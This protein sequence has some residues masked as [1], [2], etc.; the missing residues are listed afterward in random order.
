MLLL[1]GRR[2]IGGLTAGCGGA[3][4]E[5]V[6]VDDHADE[7][8]PAEAHHQPDHQAHVDF[9]GA[10][11]AVVV[12]GE[13][14]WTEVVGGDFLQV[15]GVELGREV[16]QQETE[17]VRGDGVHQEGHQLVVGL[18]VSGHSQLGH[19][20]ANNEVHA[21]LRARQSSAADEEV[22]HHGGHL[23]VFRRHAHG[24]R[25]G[26][27]KHLRVDGHVRL[28]GPDL[29][30]S[31]HLV[32][33]EDSLHGAGGGRRREADERGGTMGR[34]HGRE[35]GRSH[36]G[37]IRQGGARSGRLGGSVGHVDPHRVAVDKSPVVVCVV[38]AAHEV[39]PVVLSLGQVVVVHGTVERVRCGVQPAQRA[40]LRSAG[41]EVFQ[42]LA[43]HLRLQ[44]VVRHALVGRDQGT[45]H[46][47]A[48]KHFDIFCRGLVVHAHVDVQVL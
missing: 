3:R 26:A 44:V 29:Q 42:D 28:E 23:H 38:G 35:A 9:L 19:D 16:L 46:V 5:H 14:L 36:G 27:L 1:G 31:Q 15:G 11:R 7:E 10:A 33:V 45:G 13:A 40:A 39:V 17:L 12:G 48:F 22:V 2:G 6:Q 18:R 47:S 4:L 25:H 37:R 41:G 32:A 8:G 30:A 20:V 34:K 43:L 24:V 21:H